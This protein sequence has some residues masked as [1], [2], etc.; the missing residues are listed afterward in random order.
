MHVC[1]MSR[2][3]HFPST[4]IVAMDRVIAISGGKI[5]ASPCVVHEEAQRIQ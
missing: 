2:V 4:H 3:E 1:V 5:L